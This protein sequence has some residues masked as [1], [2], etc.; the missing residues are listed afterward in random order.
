MPLPDGTHVAY[1][2]IVLLIGKDLK[3]YIRTVKEGQRFECHLGYIEFDALVG[4]PYGSQFP[5]HMGHRLFVLI[6]HTEDIILHLQRLGQII[7][8][9]DLGYIA[10][11]LGIRPGARVIEAGTGSGALTM[12]LAMLVG[13]EG[14][15]YT[16]ER[17]NNML[18]QAIANL[19]RMDLLDRVTF[20]EKDIEEGFEEQD[21]HALFLDVRTPADYLPQA[22]AALRGGGFFGA[23]VPTMNQV[24]ELAQPLYDGP[25]YLLQIE[26]L[27]LRT[28]KTHPQRI[29]PD[30]QMVGHTGYLVFARAVER[31][32]RG[33]SPDAAPDDSA[34]PDDPGGDEL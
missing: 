18:S 4:T 20:H 13:D 30:E 17:R 10:L 12:T 8:P 21:A 23:L 11:K 19:R 2:D 26:E 32:T 1:G 25:W 3:K 24:L 29:R 31:E 14:H 15:V 27:L 33:A 22:R 6:P 34:G 7:Y 9:K 16:Y 5:T 28:Y